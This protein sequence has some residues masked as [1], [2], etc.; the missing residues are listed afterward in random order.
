LSFGFTNTDADG[1]ER[2]Q[3]LFYTEIF[4]AYSIAK[5]ELK[6]HLEIVHVERVRKTSESFS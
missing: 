2:P 3:F 4:A 6:R 5:N 1:E